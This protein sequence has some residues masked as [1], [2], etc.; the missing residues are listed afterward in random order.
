MAKRAGT[1]AKREQGSRQRV[2]R[3][4]ATVGAGLGLLKP[5][6]DALAESSKLNK[7]LAEVTTLTDEATFPVKEMKGLV[8]GLAAEYGKDATENAKALYQTISAGFGEAEQ[9]AKMR[10]AANKLAL[11]GVTEVGTAV[12]GL[13]NVMNTYSKQNL[14]SL[15]VS[16][17]FF[18]AV[19][20]GK[21]TVGELA[22]QIGRVAPGAEAMG[23]AFDEVL[24]SIAAVTTKGIDTR[25][26]V[27]GLAAALANVNKPSGDARKE[28]QRLGIEFNAAALRA[29]GL[30]GFLDSIT[31]SAGFNE[32]SIAKLFGS[33]EAFKVMTALTS[34]ESEKYNEVLAEMA[35]RTGATEAAVAKM[36]NTFEHQSNR[37][38]Q[39]R[40]NIILDCL[41]CGLFRC[42][43]KGSHIHIKSH[44]GKSR[45]DD[46]STSVMTILT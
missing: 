38:K 16:D 7:A 1:E 11:A 15:D 8:K 41:S 30:T 23:I 26:T 10:E 44:V 22:S 24:A 35:K 12:D 19:K 28:A 18:V 13:T 9:A 36:E 17:A 27:S 43:K 39:N 21:T 37:L 40:K 3:G 45:R 46:P 42:L 2:G 5:M 33:I 14:D 34:N 29:K 31:K 20:A 25:Q 4:M 32:D 6:K